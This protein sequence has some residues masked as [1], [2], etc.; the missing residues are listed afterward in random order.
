MGSPISSFMM[1]KSRHAQLASRR[2]EHVA[3]FGPCFSLRCRWPEILVP[4]QLG[5]LKA[6]VSLFI[7]RLLDKVQRYCG[8]VVGGVHH[9]EGGGNAPGSIQ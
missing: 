2:E 4:P 7:Q 6:A 5:A 3:R 9:E 1:T 8:W